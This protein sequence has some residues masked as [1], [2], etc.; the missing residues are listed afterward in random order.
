[1]LKRPLPDETRH[2]FAKV[3]RF[4]PPESA[5]SQVSDGIGIVITRR[6][7]SQITRALAVVMM[8]TVSK[9]IVRQA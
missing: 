8:T 4:K 5:I 6:R 2:L 3:N 1:M 9:F 7:P